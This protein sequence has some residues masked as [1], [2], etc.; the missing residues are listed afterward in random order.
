VRH[1]GRVRRR[2]SAG[3]GSAVV[4]VLL[5]LVVAVLAS[6]CGTASEPSPPTGV[7]EL[8]V[9]TP[10]VDPQDFVDGVDNPWLPL[11]AGA[12]W[13]YRVTGTP[14]GVAS[15]TLTVTVRDETARVAGLMATVVDTDG[16]T[17]DRT[18]YYAQDRAGNVWWVGREGVWQAGE[19][20]AEAGLAM[21][22]HPRVGDGWRRGYL[23]GVVE[24]RSEVTA[25]DAT[26]T[27]PAGSYEGVAELRT[28]SPLDPERATED[29][30]ARGVG[31]VRTVAVDAPAYV[32]DLLSGP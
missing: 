6:G 20:G 15:G 8:V 10:S 22:R 29:S 26:V 9:P 32:V 27:T 24:D 14:G 18:D 16:P 12:T 3:V 19:S 5:G 28:S 11:A 31:L 2:G 25:L 4:S 13:A 7:D 21:P 30:Y 1:D 17:G 23:V